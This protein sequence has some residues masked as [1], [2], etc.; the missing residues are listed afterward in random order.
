MS[1][2]ELDMILVASFTPDHFF[3]G[4]SSFL[5]DK[6]GC[7]TTPAMDLRVQCT[8]FVYTPFQNGARFYRL[9]SVRADPRRRRRGPQQWS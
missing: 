3:P 2:D 8:G 5:Q 1:A 4:V 9:G 7:T 6:L